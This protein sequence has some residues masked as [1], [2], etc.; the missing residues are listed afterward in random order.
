MALSLVRLSL[1]VFLPLSLSLSLSV[2]LCLPLSLFLSLP[3]ASLLI[4]VHAAAHTQ[5]CRQVRLR[6][7]E[8]QGQ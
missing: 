5:M 2:S 3:V 6:R 8:M 4:C 7:W 1:R